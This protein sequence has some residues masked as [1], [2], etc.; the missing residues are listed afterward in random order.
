MQVALYKEINTSDSGVILV[1]I[2]H[3]LFVYL[4]E[5]Q[6]LLLFLCILHL[7]LRLTLQ[8]KLRFYHKNLLV[9]FIKS[10][11]LVKRVFF[12]SY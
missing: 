12:I 1:L 4:F 9:L 11:F 5:R 8:K 6:E 2:W 7:L 10:C 3:T